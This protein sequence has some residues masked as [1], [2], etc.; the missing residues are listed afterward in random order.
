MKNLRSVSW[1]A[2]RLF[3][4][5]A[6]L[7][8]LIIPGQI[9]PK[10]GAHLVRELTSSVPGTLVICGGGDMPVHILN[11]FVEVAGGPQARIVVVTTASET[12]DTAEVETDLEFWRG[13]NLAGLDVLHTRS[14]D[15]ANDPDFTKP[16]VDATG[17]WFMGGKQSWL[18]DTY[19][20]TVT[21]QLIH[22]VLKRGGVIGGESA[23]AAIMSPVMIRQGDKQ[24]EVGKGFGFLPGTVID[25]HFIAR[26]RQDRLMNVLSKNPGMVGLGIDEGTALI[27]Q[28]RRI[29]VL[30][31]SQ[32]VA[33]LSPSSN[34]SAKLR[35][36]EAG[37]E[38]DLIQL[39]RDAK[40]RTI[41]AMRTSRNS[42][43]GAM[44]G[45]LSL[46]KT[47]TVKTSR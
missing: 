44:Y 2:R 9:D 5:S 23:G 30:G 27:V 26:N 47:A 22:A 21:E 3:A 37:A 20:D 42:S 17:I 25:Q 18:T 31:D 45:N 35:M 8:L 15:T 10:G 6:V 4:A 41:P 46:K 32:V 24:P 43:K 19:L 28:G 29:S 39:G 13:L 1:R 7:I 11:R 16:L 12:A 36:L 34:R 40:S 14:R 33:C 38:A